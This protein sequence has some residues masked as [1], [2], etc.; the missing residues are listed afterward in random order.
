[1]KRLKKVS[2]LLLLLFFT[3]CKGIIFNPDFYVFDRVNKSLVNE[4]G[5]VLLWESE[6]VDTFACM[7]EAK[8]EELKTLLMKQK[9]NI[10]DKKFIAQKFSDL[11]IRTSKSP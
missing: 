8:I 4:S 9:F 6:R 10:R 11:K 1:M 7:S 2:F 3:S 5:D